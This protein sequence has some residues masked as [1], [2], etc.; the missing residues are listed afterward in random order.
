MTGEAPR[1]ERS[2]SVL[3]LAPGGIAPQETLR[4]GHWYSTTQG[5]VGLLFALASLATIGA[6]IAQAAGGLDLSIHDVEALKTAAALTGVVGLLFLWASKSPVAV[7]EAS[8]SLEEGYEQPF[9]LVQDSHKSEPEAAVAAPATE[10]TQNAEVPGEPRGLWNK[11]EAAGYVRWAS[12]MLP[13]GSNPAEGK[14][15]SHLILLSHYLVAGGTMTPSLYEDIQ[16]EVVRAG[17]ELARQAGI[18]SPLTHEKVTA[19]LQR[20]PDSP[21]LKELDRLLNGQDQL[22]RQWSAMRALA[23]SMAALGD[24]PGREGDS[25]ATQLRGFADYEAAS[26]LASR[27]GDSL[28][29]RVVPGAPDGD[30][31]RLLRLVEIR[32]SLHRQAAQAVSTMAQLAGIELSTT[33]PERYQAVRALAKQRPE[34]LPYQELVSAQIYVQKR[35]IVDGQ[36]LGVD[37]K[38]PLDQQLKAA[39]SITPMGPDQRR[40]VAQLIELIQAEL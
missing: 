17:D 37:L 21:I 18:R 32:N 13:P 20:T 22:A 8:M 11:L 35:A 3:S 27:R 7:K 1:L 14:L 40:T 10:P 25:L 19:A 26:T 24:Y 4:A 5:Q 6:L 36:H 12:A 33:L 16:S 28:G 15:S 34:L 38:A 2:Q 30:P 39:Q 9:I 23:D 29:I 31:Y